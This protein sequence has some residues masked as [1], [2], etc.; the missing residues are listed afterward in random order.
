MTKPNTGKRAKSKLVHQIKSDSALSAPRRASIESMTS[1]SQLNSNPDLQYGKGTND[2]IL[3]PRLKMPN[4]PT[5][6]SFP[7][8]IFEMSAVQHVD[9]RT[10]A[11][12]YGGIIKRG[13]FDEHAKIMKEFEC[14]KVLASAPS[15]EDEKHPKRGL[16]IKGKCRRQWLQKQSKRGIVSSSNSGG[17]DKLQQK[18]ISGDPIVDYKEMESGDDNNKAESG[19]P[20]SEDTNILED[21]GHHCKKTKLTSSSSSSSTKATVEF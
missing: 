1:A 2:A 14:A 13:H 17:N 19:C 8:N 6:T 9:E 15:A 16:S 5:S 18:D 21:K 7:M 10:A 11:A 3:D 20:K 12:D 4:I